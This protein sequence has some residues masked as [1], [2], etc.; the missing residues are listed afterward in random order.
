[1]FTL[2]A[3]LALVIYG[4]WSMKNNPTLAPG[5][6]FSN[7]ETIV[8]KGTAVPVTTS[9]NT[10]EEALLTYQNTRIQLN[11]NCQATPNNVTYK[12]N[13]NVMIDNRAGVARTVKIGTTLSIPAYGFKIVKLTSTTFPTTFL[14]DCDK[15]QNIATILL[16]K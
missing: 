11:N 6:N 16:Q 15:S 9:R 2:V 13:T 4:L 8:D 3:V 5:V 10:Y 14:V 12:N 1:M 7:P